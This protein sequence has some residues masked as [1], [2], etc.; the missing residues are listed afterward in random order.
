MKEPYRKG[1]ANHPGP[2]SCAGGR[3]APGE[4][5]TG[6]HAGQLLT[7]EITSLACRPCAYMG[8]ATS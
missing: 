5:W 1:V 8:K 2:E 7:S 6:V 3:E 4:A